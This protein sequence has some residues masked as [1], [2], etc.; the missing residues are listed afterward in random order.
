[1]ENPNNAITIWTILAAVG[2]GAIISAF[3]GL[4]GKIAGNKHAFKMR[5]EQD[6][7]EYIQ[8]RNRTLYKHLEELERECGIFIFTDSEEALNN[9]LEVHHKMNI[10]YNLSVPL[11]SE[12]HILNLGELKNKYKR[13]YGV[14]YY[15]KPKDRDEY[16]WDNFISW[17]NYSKKF[18][19]ML[20]ATIKEEL[21]KISNSRT[22]GKNDKKNSRR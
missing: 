22:E 4:M 15:T 3:I 12:Q 16:F 13:E 8:Y 20:S 9:G 14:V 21:I 2:F 10:I 17:I 18:K 1:M 5:K 6:M 7:Y 19:D 11:L